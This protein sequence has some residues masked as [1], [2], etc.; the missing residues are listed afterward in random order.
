MYCREVYRDAGVLVVGAIH[1]KEHL[2]V[3]AS[4][5]VLITDGTNEPVEVVGPKVV[6]SVPGTKRAVLS[7]EPT[8]CMTFHVTDAKTVEEAEK[9][10][11][12]AEPSMYG[13]GN[14]LKTEVLK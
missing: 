12:E 14:V 9:E 11:I 13:P 5:R 7:L 3:I 4:G 8:V 1:R 6:L 2:Y 10:L